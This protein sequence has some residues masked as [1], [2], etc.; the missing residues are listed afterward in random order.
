MSS[1]RYFY[2]ILAKL[3]FSR[4][5]FERNLNTKFYHS[6]SSRSRVVSCMQTD[7]R[8]DRYDECNSGFLL[9]CE[10]A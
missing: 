1:I 8:I 5:I 3:E 2:R 7:G 4:Q 6:V 9:F 10:L